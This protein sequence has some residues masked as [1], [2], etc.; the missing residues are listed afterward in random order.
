[1]TPL[2]IAL[3][4]I[5]AGWAPVPMPHKQ[6]RPTLEGWEILRIGAEDA[7]RFFNGGP[8]NIGVLLGEPSDGLTDIDLDCDEAARAAPYFLPKTHCFGRASKR[9]S[10]WLY[11]TDLWQNEAK[12]TLQFAQQIVKEDGR[13]SKKTLL[14]CRVGATGSAAQTVFPGSTHPSGEAIAWE[15]KN[16]FARVDGAQLLRDCRFLASV[17]ILARHFPTVGGR[18]EAGLTVGGFLARCGLKAPAGKL[19]AEALGAA[20]V[21]PGDKRRD[22]IRTVE[23]SINDFAAGKPVAGLPKLKKVFGEEPAKKCANWL[24]YKAEAGERADGKA[25]PEEELTALVTEDS[26]ALEFAALHTGKLLFDHDAGCWFEWAGP[27][28]RKESTGLAF[29][30]ARQLA[31]R[32]SEGKKAGTRYALRKT[33]FASGVERYARVDRAFAVTSERWDRDPFLLGTPGG[34]VDLHTGALRDAEPADAISKL[35]AVAPAAEPDCPRFMAFLNEATGG[36]D[37]LI[38]FLQ[39]FCGYCLTGSTREH[40]LLFIHGAGGNGKGVF[41]NVVSWIMGDYALT[42][43]MDMF[44][45]SNQDKHTTDVAMLHCARLV[46]ASET[47]KNR[48]WNENLIKLI[49]GGDR[50]TARFMRQNNFSFTP[51]F[52]LLVLGNH[53]PKLQSVNEAMRRRFNIVPFNHTPAAPDTELDKKLRAEAQGILRWMIDGCLDWQE[54][55]GL[56]RP[57]SVNAANAEYFAAQD[58]FGQW[59]EDEC[60]V[61]P[62]NKWKIARSADLFKAWSDYAR[63]AGE[64]PGTQTGFAEEL[65]QRELEPHKGTGGAR[66]FRGIRLKPGAESQ[67]AGSGG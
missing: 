65:K 29:E 11:F 19:F 17:T 56:A 40:A 66:M 63:R 26:A 6:K 45:A 33:S 10:H 18:H 51:T 54:A 1:M 8:Q 25:A 28:W 57:Q 36:D 53:K 9:A 14:E 61:E 43:A 46:T 60:D 38:R 5:R 27:H 42:A 67:A 16:E 24:G 48:T 22:I 20:T 4:Y 31:R 13:K 3:D 15:D 2:E 30:W 41:L 64:S 12:A 62:G 52:K 35:T 23:D 59:L 39:Q 50:L 47:A 44:V 21:Q 55:N 49:T 32:L 34:T 37:A 58:I 7:P